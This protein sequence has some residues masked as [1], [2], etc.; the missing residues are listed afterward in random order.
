MN[1]TAKFEQ[2]Q[3]CLIM[4]GYA[5]IVGMIYNISK[6]AE[7]FEKNPSYNLYSPCSNSYE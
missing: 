7:V 5:C 3:I 2:R 1:V 6:G 4:P